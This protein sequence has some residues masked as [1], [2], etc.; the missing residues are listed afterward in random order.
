MTGSTSHNIG[1]TADWEKRSAALWASIDDHEAEEFVALID[2]LAA[3]LPAGSA[4]AAFERGCSFDSTGQSD[5]AV[6]LYQEALDNGLTGE[7]RR[8]AVIQMSS[9][10]R[11]LGRLEEGVRL[12]TAEL[13]QG[14]D[15]LDDAVKTTLALALTDL[16]RER[17]AVS[18]LVGALARHLPRYQRSMANYARGLLES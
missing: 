17:E 14:S 16:G 10:L 15:Q 3:E 9:S 7:R 8:R 11:N 2:E 18:L 1:S 12:L 5:R 13:D 6:V 4:L